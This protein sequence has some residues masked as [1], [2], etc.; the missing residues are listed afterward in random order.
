MKMK[1]RNQRHKLC[2]KYRAITYTYTH[3]Y[4]YK[5]MH[6][7]I[8]GIHKYAI[9]ICHETLSHTHSHHTHTH[10][11]AHTNSVYIRNH[12]KQRNEY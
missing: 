1:Y 11:Q 9:Q 5:Y 7:Y 4:I 10:T 12:V 3:I 2:F 6:K 8:Y